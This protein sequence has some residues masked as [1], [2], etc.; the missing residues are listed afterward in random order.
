ME[1][2][3]QAQFLLTLP[4]SL[5]NRIMDSAYAH[6]RHPMDEFIYRLYQSFEIEPDKPGDSTVSDTS[7]QSAEDE[8]S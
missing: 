8:L 6:N 1:L 7:K 2:I 3:N 4:K 5:F